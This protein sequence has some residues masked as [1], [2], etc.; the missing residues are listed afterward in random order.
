[1][2]F[3]FIARYGA[4]TV[5]FFDNIFLIPRADG[6]KS[7]PPFDINFLNYLEEKNKFFS[8]YIFPWKLKEKQLF[9]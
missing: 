9:C 6:T 3:E 7:T 4:V 5:T 2:C 1:M 8:E